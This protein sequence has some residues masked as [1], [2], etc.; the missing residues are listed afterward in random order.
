MMQSVA[1][2]SISRASAA[3]MPDRSTSGRAGSAAPKRS[4][5]WRCPIHNVTRAISTAV[6][7]MSKPWRLLNG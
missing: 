6:G 5:I 4:I 3:W 2:Q 1:G 7:S